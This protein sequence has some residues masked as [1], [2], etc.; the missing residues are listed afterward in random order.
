MGDSDVAASE[1]VTDDKD[2]AAIMAVEMD[3]VDVVMFPVACFR[4]QSSWTFPRLGCLA[5][6]RLAPVG[7]TRLR[8][9]GSKAA[10]LA[11]RLFS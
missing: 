7:M 5:L 11:E 8:H 6:D 1:V 9:A 3:A 4:T 10:V 2:S